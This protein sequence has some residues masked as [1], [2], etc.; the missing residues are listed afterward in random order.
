MLLNASIEPA[1]VE[2]RIIIS[3]L[4]D[5]TYILEIAKLATMNIMDIRVRAEAAEQLL[6]LLA[7]SSSP[8]GAV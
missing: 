5:L 2:K 1:T 7:E 8:D 4:C 6:K 3:C